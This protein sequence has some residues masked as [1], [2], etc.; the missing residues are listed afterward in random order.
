MYAHRANIEGLTDACKTAGVA[1]IDD[2][3]HLLGA[4]DAALPIPGT[5]GSFGL[6]S[7]AQSKSMACG[8]SGAG[9]LLIVNETRFEDEARAAIDDLPPVAADTRALAFAL[10]GRAIA[11]GMD[12]LWRLTSLLER[13]MDS[14]G[15]PSSLQAARM[16]ALHLS[17]ALVQLES[18]DTRIADKRRV[19][20]A[21]WQAMS[22]AVRQAFVQYAPGRYLTRVMLRARTIAARNE[23][24]ERL[25]EAGVATRAGYPA[26]G[27][28]SL[29]GEPITEL[30]LSRCQAITILPLRRSSVSLRFSTN[31]PP[32]I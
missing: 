24:R 25:A 9:G 21:Y 11:P 12:P 6:V 22:P 27:A 14:D 30:R 13:G 28:N 15:E 32:R 26:V 7:F 19:A 2:A 8:Y 17:L 10:S 29:S 20:G 5:G 23:L 4:P 18:L 31:T 3:A 1:L 16:P